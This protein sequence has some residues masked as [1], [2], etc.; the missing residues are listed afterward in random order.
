MMTNKVDTLGLGAQF[1]EIFKNATKEVAQAKNSQI[2]IANNAKQKQ[3]KI[4][5][6]CS[7][8]VYLKEQMEFPLY[9]GK[10]PVFR[11]INGKLTF[12]L[13]T[14]LQGDFQAEYDHYCQCCIGGYVYYLNCN[15]KNNQNRLEQ[16]E[17]EKQVQKIKYC[18]YSEQIRNLMQYI[19]TEPDYLRRAQLERETR[20]CENE[21]EKSLYKTHELDKERMILTNEQLQIME[22]LDLIKSGNYRLTGYYNKQADQ[23][24]FILDIF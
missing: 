2:A 10:R 3:V 1:L 19:Y 9:Q 4:N 11:E 17:F 7:W 23:K 13:N 24:A 18:N 15:M 22:V 14:K 20:F 5:L 12:P 8:L 6:A 16:I 21:R